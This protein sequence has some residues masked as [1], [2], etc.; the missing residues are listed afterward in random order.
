MVLRE[1]RDS[2]ALIFAQKSSRVTHIGDI[3]TFI[4]YQTEDSTGSKIKKNK[5]I[6]PDFSPDLR[7]SSINCFSI[8]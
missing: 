8:R 6:Y 3:T 2:F 7:L 5:A 1:V 4:Y